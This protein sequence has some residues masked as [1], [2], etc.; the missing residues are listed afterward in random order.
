MAAPL[1]RLCGGFAGSSSRGGIGVKAGEIGLAQGHSGLTQRRIAH[2]QVEE[3]VRQA[4]KVQEIADALVKVGQSG[5]VL[6]AAYLGVYTRY[7]IDTPVG[8]L[9]V[10]EQNSGAANWQRGQQISLSWAR[11]HMRQL[12]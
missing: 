6:D 3:K 12:K 8:N 4:E 9:L 2:G 10:I 11:E 7:T 5:A 1:A